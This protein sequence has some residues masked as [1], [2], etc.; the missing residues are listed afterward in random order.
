MTQWR[1]SQCPNLN[2]WQTKALKVIPFYYDAFYAFYAF[3]A[4]W[5]LVSSLRS[6]SRSRT[7]YFSN[8]LQ[9]LSHSGL[10]VDKIELNTSQKLKD[11]WRGFTVGIGC[12]FCFRILWR[13][14]CPVTACPSDVVTVMPSA[15]VQSK[16]GTSA[17]SAQ[18]L[19]GSVSFPA[20]LATLRPQ[21]NSGTVVAESKSFNLRL[22]TCTTDLRF[23]SI[24]DCSH[25]LCEIL[26]QDR[27]SWVEPCQVLYLWPS[28]DFVVTVPY[29][30]KYFPKYLPSFVSLPGG[31]IH[32]VW[33]SRLEV[34]YRLPEKFQS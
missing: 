13:K 7:I 22:V 15:W 16:N 32:G 4:W 34:Y 23:R 25:W 11:S 9:S 12:S 5:F 24:R 33:T 27:S 2:K 29:Y 31:G 26:A 10:K 20:N 3:Y 28:Q 17:Y 1:R 6:R 21:S 30:R 8:V 14:K 18:R 19:P